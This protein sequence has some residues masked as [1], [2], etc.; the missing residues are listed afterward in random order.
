M[1]ELNTQRTKFNC[2]INAWQFSPDGF[3]SEE[4]GQSTDHLRMDCRLCLSWGWMIWQK[5]PILQYIKIFH[6][7]ICITIC[8]F[9]NNLLAKKECCIE[10]NCEKQEYNNNFFNHQENV[11]N[12]KNRKNKNFTF[13]SFK[14][15]IYNCSNEFVAFKQ[16]L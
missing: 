5:K 10:K 15:S 1:W 6:W 14:V 11:R 9:A 13:Y 7:Y 8:E 12:V 3:A 16:G 4:I 2:Y